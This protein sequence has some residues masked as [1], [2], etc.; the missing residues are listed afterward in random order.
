[1]AGTYTYPGV[2][3]EELSSG[4]RTITGVSTSV[5]AFLGR[6]ARGPTDKPRTVTSFAEFES[7]YG[8]LADG[9][10]LPFAVRD[11]FLNGGSVA[12]V[13]RLS[14]T[15]TAKATTTLPDA[16]TLVLEAKTAGVGGN[17]LKATIT[18]D[19]GDANKFTLNIKDDDN[20]IDESYTGDIATFTIP[21]SSV[22]KVKSKSGSVRPALVT[23]SRFTGGIDSAVPAS[24]S[25]IASATNKL[26]L[27]AANGGA[28]GNNLSVSV[29]DFTS[30]TGTGLFNLTVF[31]NKV[32]FTSAL[33][34]AAMVRI[35]TEVF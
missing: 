35:Q 22:V 31:L 9:L 21:A 6:T 34:S 25:L 12:V 11:F 24:L 8:G 27:E 4:V 7:L 17:K 19:L 10:P 5:T 30:V 14:T 16:N 32:P 13:G 28:W 20:L 2:Y 33:G 1:M 23:D 26:Q 3:I 29:D 18:H 15:T